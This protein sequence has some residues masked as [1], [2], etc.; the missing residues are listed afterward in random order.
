ML[1]PADPPAQLIQVCEKL[2][3]PID[4]DGVCVGDVETAFN[5]CGANE[6]VDF[7]GNESRHNAF[8]FVG[9]HLAMPDLN[10]G[11]WAKIDDPIAHARDGRYAIVQEEYLPLP[12]ELAIN[13]RANKPL[14]IS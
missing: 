10:S 12:F 6:H 4:D 5:D 11:L 2:V 13:R 9:I 3:R 1:G 7:P 8:Q 14:I